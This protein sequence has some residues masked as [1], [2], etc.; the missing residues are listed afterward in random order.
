MRDTCCETDAALR[1]RPHKRRATTVDH[2]NTVMMTAVRSAPPPGPPDA[3]PPIGVA[4]TFLRAS[5]VSLRTSS[6][7]RS[8]P[9]SSENFAVVMMNFSLKTP[10]VA[11]FLRNSSRVIGFSYAGLHYGYD[12]C[13]AHCRAA[14]TDRR[15][16]HVLQRFVGEFAHVLVGQL[17][18]ELLV[19][20]CG[21][22]DELQSEDAVGGHPLAEFIAG[23]LLLLRGFRNGPP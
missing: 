1:R 4:A 16:G 7:D 23:H 10:S 3:P 20:L 6:S 15:H 13:R 8:S 22:D 11:I 14:A 21:L 19:E 5:S 18:A 9:S 12:D 17:Q 2:Q